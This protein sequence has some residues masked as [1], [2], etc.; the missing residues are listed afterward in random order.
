MARSM[1]D[2]GVGGEAKGEVDQVTNRVR[3]LRDTAVA[4]MLGCFEKAAA[5]VV[6]SS[7]G[8]KKKERRV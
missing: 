1:Y 7:H 2:Y 4:G 6:W 3:A 5:E 8:A